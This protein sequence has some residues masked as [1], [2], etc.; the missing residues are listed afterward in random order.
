MAKVTRQIRVSP[1]VEDMVQKIAD[2]EMRT[3]SNCANWLLDLAAQRYLLERK[4]EENH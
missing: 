1:E 4:D 2:L 3:F